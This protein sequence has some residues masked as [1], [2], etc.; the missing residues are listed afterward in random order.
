MS[1]QSLSVIEGKRSENSPHPW[2]GGVEL[3]V[4]RAIRAGYRVGRRVWIGH[5]AGYVVGYNIG[6]FGRF[7]GA[8][9]PLLVRTE[10]GVTKCSLNEVAAA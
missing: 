10:F 6:S 3:A 4:N 9:Y 5:V 2:H 7:S 8:S 1:T